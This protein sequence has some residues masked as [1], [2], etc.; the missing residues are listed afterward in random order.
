MSNNFFEFHTFVEKESDWLKAY[1]H[2][3]NGI[4]FVITDGLRYRAPRGTLNLGHY[5]KLCA[6]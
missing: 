6:K 5:I 1:T 3:V 2:F 4:G